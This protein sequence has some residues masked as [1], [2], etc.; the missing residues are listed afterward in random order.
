M[1]GNVFHC[2]VQLTRTSNKKKKKELGSISLHPQ[3]RLTALANR[4]RTQCQFLGPCLKSMATSISCFLEHACLPVLRRLRHVE[5]SFERMQVNSLSWALSQ[6]QLPAPWKGHLL[7]HSHLPTYEVSPNQR[8]LASQSSSQ[9][10]VLLPSIQSLNKLTTAWP[11][12]QA[13]NGNTIMSKMGRGH[14]V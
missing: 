13:N 8:T 5:K 4:D 1:N 10:Q 14:C 9:C 11:Q 2:H 7:H 3:L 12:T 6:K